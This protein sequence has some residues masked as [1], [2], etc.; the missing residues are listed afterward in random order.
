MSATVVVG[1]SVRA[2]VRRTD[3]QCLHGRWVLD[4]RAAEEPWSRRCKVFL[5]KE[6]CGELGAR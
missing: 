2:R 4:V 5:K 3:W 1:A 6:V